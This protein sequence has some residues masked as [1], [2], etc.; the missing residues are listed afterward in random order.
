MF[1]EDT[2]KHDIDFDKYQVVAL[3]GGKEIIIKNFDAANVVDNSPCLMCT[4]ILPSNNLGNSL[5]NMVI[6][7]NN[8]LYT[9]KLFDNEKRIIRQAEGAI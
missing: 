7:K 6:N 9:R 4:G 2:L 3:V 5:V 8:V 1:K